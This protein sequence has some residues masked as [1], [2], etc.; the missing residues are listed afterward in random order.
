MELARVM[1]QYEFDKTLVFV[2]FAGEEQGPPSAVLCWRRKPTRKTWSIGP[3]L[4]N[5]IIGTDVSG[6]GRMGNGAVN[7][8]SDE[9]MDSI[10]QQLSRYVREIV[11]RPTCHP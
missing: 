10:S 4:N 7:V 2:V 5:D 3:C 11:E 9:T 1:S 8:Y 6:N